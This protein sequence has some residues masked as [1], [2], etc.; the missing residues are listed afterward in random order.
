MAPQPPGIARIHTGRDTELVSDTAKSPDEPTYTCTFTPGF[1]DHSS[2]NLG[3]EAFLEP[4]TYPTLDFWNEI[5]KWKISA[6]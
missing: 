4:Q 2:K 1:R 3:L 6:K 5:W